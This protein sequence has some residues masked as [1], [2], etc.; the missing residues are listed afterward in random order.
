MV[1]NDDVERAADELVRLVDS[2]AREPAR[3]SIQQGL[4]ES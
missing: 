1:V 3:P 4:S 2:P